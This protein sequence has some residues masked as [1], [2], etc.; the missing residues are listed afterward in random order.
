MRNGKHR[1]AKK[2]APGQQLGRD[3]ARMQNQGLQII[4]SSAEKIRYRAWLLAGVPSEMAPP[5]PSQIQ[6]S[7]KIHPSWEPVFDV[8]RVTG[9]AGICL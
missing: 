7:V 9:Q 2:I 6:I 8:G 5:S 3:G 1:E 4:E